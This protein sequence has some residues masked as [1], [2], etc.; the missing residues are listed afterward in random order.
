[1]HLV[2]GSILSVLLGFFDSGLALTVFVACGLIQLVY[3]VPAMIVCKVRNR[4][5]IVKGLAIVA[6]VTFLLNAGCWGLAMATFSL[7]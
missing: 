3:L 7:H 5:K 4:P 6:A 2:A 1:M